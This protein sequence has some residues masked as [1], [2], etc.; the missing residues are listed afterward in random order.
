[1]AQLTRSPQYPATDLHDAIK[2]VQSVYEKE[3]R[4]SAP[5]EAVVEDIGYKGASGSSNKIVSALLKYG[6]LE[7]HNGGFRVSD[8]AF[9]ILIHEPKHPERAEAVREAAFRPVLFQRLYKEY[10]MSLPSDTNL[11]TRLLKE[12][13]NQNVVNKVIRIYRETINFVEEENSDEA[14]V[15]AETVELRPLEEV[16]EPKKSSL[17]KNLEDDRDKIVEE[18][19]ALNLPTYGADERVKGYTLLDEGW[20]SPLHFKI[21]HDCEVRLAFKGKIT[22]KGM[23]KL[24]RLLEIST[25]IYPSDDG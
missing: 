21:A 18:R 4:H 10:G 19:S 1:M 20:H 5:K 17:G 6:L 2:R 24:I 8:I 7:S 16:I 9:T 3:G 11:R 15:D 23:T 25:D 13:F 22:Q 14:T 12:D